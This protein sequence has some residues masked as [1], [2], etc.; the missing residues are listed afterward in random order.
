MKKLIL[1]SAA[2]VALTVSLPAVAA[3]Q[4][5][6][7]D[8][9][10]QRLETPIGDGDGFAASGALLFGT[11]SPINLQLDASIAQSESV[12][13]GGANLHAFHR[14]ESFAVGGFVGF[15]DSEFIDAIIQ[16]GL[17]GAFYLDAVTLGATVAQLD[18][19]DLGLE[20]TTLQGAATFFPNDN[21]SLGASYG[22]VDVDGVGDF[23]VF[24]LAAEFK[25]NGPVSFFANYG[26]AEDLDVD[27]FGLGVRYN[28]GGKT[29]KERDRSGA[30]MGKST[31]AQFLF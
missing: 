7:V 22:N 8:L 26:R 20:A 23:D 28:F 1:A 12:T 14:N 10:Y 19:D 18:S 11:G 9:S 16:Y 29:L 25:M 5:D 6:H 3:A 21:V 13:G 2:A 30:S 4:V 17:E 27:I 24:G 15:T 31:A